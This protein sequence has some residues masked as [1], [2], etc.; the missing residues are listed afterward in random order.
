M[1]T[2]STLHA[3]NSVY[4]TEPNDKPLQFNEVSGSVILLGE[5]DSND[6][7]GYRWTI[8]DVDAQQS[9]TIS[10]QGVP[11]RLSVVDVIRLTYADN[12]VDV[13]SQDKL[14]T[15][16]SRDGSKP[17]VIRDL[18][19]EPG[20]Y[21]LGVA[22]GGATKALY[23][24]PTTKLALDGAEVQD[25][26][27]EEAG[28]YRLTLGEG[29]KITIRNP[30]KD[31]ESKESALKLRL[32]SYYS[33]FHVSKST[34]Y[35][36]EFEEKHTQNHWEVKG[37]VPVGREAH[38]V[39]RGSGGEELAK[40]VTDRFGH[41]LLPDLGLD[42]G[43]YYLDLQTE[44]PNSVRSVIL[45]PTG[46]R[47]SN[48]E[49]EPND[50]WLLANH[51]NA[52]DGITGR[53]G[54]SGEADFYR[55]E[56][57]EAGAEQRF[58]LQLETIS[59]DKVTLC[60][61]DSEGKSI[62]CRESKG[63][64]SLPDLVL[65]SG[66]WGYVVKRGA[67]SLEYKVTLVHQGDIQG[68]FETEPNDSTKYASTIPEKLRIKGAFSAKED[69]YYRLVITGEPQLWRFQVMGDNIHEL[70]YHDAS[71]NPVQVFR[72]QSG[73]RRVRLDN[74]YL[75]PGIHYIRVSGKSAGAYT[76]LAKAVG[77]P[78]PDA[79]MEPNDDR[80]RLSPLR[81]GQTR[82]GVLQDKA[83]RDFYRFHLANYDHIQLTIA[84]PADG[85]VNV[86]LYWDGAKFKE[87]NQGKPGKPAELEGL[88]PPGDYQ[89]FIRAVE[90][91][92]AEYKLSLKRLP[93]FSC[94]V[95]CEPNDTS[96]FA[97]PLPAGLSF[98]GRVNEWRDQDWFLLPVR[99]TEQAIT[100]HVT[101]KRGL[102]V[103][104]EYRGASYVKWDNDVGAFRGTLPAGIQTYIVIGA[105]G[106]PPY[107]LTIQ[108]DDEPL[109][110]EPLI[111][112]NDAGVELSLNLETKAVAAYL[113]RGQKIQGELQ[114]L[115][116]SSE[117]VQV[118]LDSA[119]SDHRWQVQLARPDVKIPPGET[120]KI[121]VQI[122]VPEDAW[123]DRLVSISIRARSA[124]G[125][126]QET[127]QDVQ[128]ERDTASA[129][130]Q[131]SWPL[132][133]QLLGGFNV[134]AARLGG[135][136]LDIPD[137]GTVG[138]GFPELI[139]DMAVRDEGLDLRSRPKGETRAFTL[140][141]AGNTPIEVAGFAVNL[142][143]H[144]ELIYQLR[145][146]DVSLSVDG[147]NFEQVLNA[148]LLPI[149]TEQAFVLEN[150]QT[151]RYA[152][153]VLE[154]S[155][156]GRPA[157]AGV[158]LGEF[159][160]IA[161]PGLD[162]SEGRGFNLS[163]PD[164]GGHVVW[165]SPRISRS[166]WD[167]NM[168]AEDGKFDQRRVPAGQGMQWVLGFHHDRAARIAGLEWINAAKADA[169]QKIAQ[170]AVSVSQ[171]SPVG[172]WLPVGEWDLSEN[173]PFTLTDET[174][175]RFIRFSVAPPGKQTTFALPDAL[176]V[177]EMPGSDDYRSI[178]TEW[179][180]ANQSAFYEYSIDQQ[181]EPAALV[182]G[183]T[184]RETALALPL[185]KAVAGEVML[186]RNEDWYQLDMPPGDNTIILNLGGD[187]TV[188][189]VVSAETKSGE[190]LLVNKISRDSTP[191]LHQ[192]EITTEPGSSV[193]L[194][195][196]EPP[197][198]VV[199]LWDT[200]PSIGA[201]LPLIYNALSSYARDL[202]PG[203]DAANMMPFGGD[204]MLRD[205]YGDP[206]ILQTVVNDYPR[207][208]S[209]SAAEQ[210]LAK[211]SRYLAPRAGTKA[212]VVITDAATGRDG[213]V[214]QEF[215][216]VQPRVFGLGISSEGAFSSNPVREQDLMQDWSRVNGGF[217]NY[218]TSQGELE[219]A[220]DRAATLLRRPAR[221]ELSARSLFREAP[222]PGSL[223]VVSSG[224]N[225]A[226]AGGAVE[227]IL[228]A[229][230]SML[231]RMG[232]ERRI[233]IA[234]KVLIEAVAE[235]IPAGTPLALRVFGHREPNAC[236]TDLEVPL[237]PLD[238][239]AVSLTLSGI[240][241]RNL[242]KTPIADSLAR[243]SSD[244]KGAQGSKVVVLV[245]D[246]EETCN[247]DPQKVIQK[248]ADDG[249]DFV[250]NIV[251]FAID[252][253]ALEARF[254]SWAEQGGGEYFPAN[255]RAGLRQSIAAA[256]RV[257]YEVFDAAGESVA[258]GLVD[259]QVI[260]LPQG[261]YRVLVRTTPR[262]VFD[263]VIVAGEESVQLSLKPARG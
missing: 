119:A 60:L 61:T 43:V 263:K 179:G 55:F 104:D 159:K 218:I 260:E 97:N 20:E 87:F 140:E 132:P 123:A 207:K 105:W 196:A 186:D 256:L 227:L 183:H 122:N 240:Q 26:A 84:P 192:L 170:V 151:A 94:G 125:G 28:G 124:N 69:D 40:T 45:R 7:D 85:S 220:Y 205:W 171:D 217:Y 191:S 230:G 25:I 34:W 44:T 23:S 224:G 228:D 19:F 155:L 137:V 237:A 216:E 195:V 50:S 38:V 8:S 93:R 78:N 234:R 5:L 57:D 149:K 113:K 129:E 231:K 204:L 164:L 258:K 232:G 246:G 135:K 145:T 17:I 214:W 114:L 250:L 152:R 189:T 80:T 168:L 102:D 46:E 162:L 81:M 153:I 15:L 184:S 241:A 198:N 30:G 54:K 63:D 165:S 254:Q 32:N 4:E 126:Q 74:I 219:V 201:Y 131:A 206:Y 133:E 134:A 176:R 101:P 136:W 157:G 172:P 79:E 108:F 139:D 115:N 2:A 66:Q 116:T 89:L 200:S 59:T 103:F 182:S 109:S 68:G 127:S 181:A 238:V 96:G 202:V 62:Q 121:P 193:Y 91:S 1:L 42:A 253:A 65:P 110:A 52:L 154:D 244:L 118:S 174:W 261:E 199:F 82:T 245:S 98:E 128:V 31:P 188:R 161:S 92:E 249:L 70:A 211:A 107:Q 39:L 48:S 262:Q 185:E 147:Q 112:V 9:W 210:T 3:Y 248:M 100:I 243:V 67:E 142:M 203:R 158:R 208:E 117:A 138:S 49:A 18:I 257:P 10:F 12:G 75:L 223:S 229:S 24:P 77:Q 144:D 130:T 247:G 21:I 73:Q 146:L 242:A 27:D 64:I 51:I 111:P 33:A 83:D 99:Q 141:L 222:G 41:Y 150:P 239:A 148:T 190:P 56:I 212:I 236:R 233:E 86:T 251:G 259:G 226:T 187:P 76:L 167:S 6:Q 16:G 255:D 14:A 37:T 175:A 22:G 209:S 194:K 29:R 13:L 197:R 221:Y 35:R 47:V 215:N 173:A 72:T 178:L 120:A 53:M 71:G 90:T 169:G 143:G 95:D 225:S 180:H 213:R 160:V 177:M 235:L 156:Y 11:G 252:D 166:N 106:D 163:R 58:T 88:F 36:F